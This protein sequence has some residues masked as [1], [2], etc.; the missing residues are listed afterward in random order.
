M[1]RSMSPSIQ[2]PSH[3]VPG[4]SFGATAPHANLVADLTDVAGFIGLEPRV[5]NAM[6]PSALTGGPPLVGHAFFVSVS[7]FQLHQNGVR[8][9][10]ARHASP[11][12]KLSQSA[13]TIPIAD[14]ETIVYTIAV[15]DRRGTASLISASRAMPVLPGTET[16]PLDN[17]VAA[18][19][20]AL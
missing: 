12:V 5:R 15:G 1:T 13:T 16:A 3:R 17:D 11:L 18:A 9:T 8:A 20:A 14:G 4:V 6:P 7:T 19:V 10:G 2:A